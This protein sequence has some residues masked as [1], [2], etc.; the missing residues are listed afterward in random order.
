M[1]GK[2]VSLDGQ[3]LHGH[4]R[5]GWW[6]VNTIDGW[7]ETPPEKSTPS[8]VVNGHGSIPVPVY[9][10]PRTVTLKGRL[11]A[12]SHELAVDAKRRLSALLQ[13]SGELVVVDGGGVA[14]SAQASRGR[15]TP[16]P[17]KGRWLPFDM[18]LKFPDPFKYGASRSFN[19]AL[20]SAVTVYQRGYFGAWPIITVTGSAPGGYAVSLGGRLVRVVAPLV[21]GSPH[22][23]DMRTGILRAGGVRVHA[24]ITVAEYWTVPP[25]IRSVVGTAPVT[26]GTATV[27]VSFKD[28]YI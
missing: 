18:E 14:L 6:Q 4:D 9:Y 13:E 26:T 3:V 1:A 28:T 12:K 22:T 7:D 19:V 20:G 24:G 15:I 10:G 11:I 8:D 27:A 17:V 23:L 25:G 21:S 2:Q 5:F 16:G